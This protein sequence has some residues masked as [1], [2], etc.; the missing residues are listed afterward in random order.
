MNALR[1]GGSYALGAAGGI[2]LAGG[3]GY[4]GFAALST[5]NPLVGAIAFGGVALSNTVIEL[6]GDK[7][8][9]VQKIITGA[10]GGLFSSMAATAA[11]QYLG[12]PIGLATCYW[13]Q[14]KVIFCGAA[15]AGTA[16]LITL[17]AAGAGILAYASLTA[18]P[19]TEGNL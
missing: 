4:I 7:M 1:S 2:V 15:L 14:T 5:C 11:S 9:L 3:V 17:L 13:L 16:L 8:T 12:T 6:T 18:N 19:S 10:V